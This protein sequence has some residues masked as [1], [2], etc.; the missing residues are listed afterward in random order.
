GGDGADRP[1]A[2]RS[3]ASLHPA[4]RV[5]GA[6]PVS[7]VQLDR[8]GRGQAVAV[9]IRELEKTFTLH[10]Q[11]GV[12]LPVLRRVSLVV[13]RGECVVLADPSGAGKSRRLGAVYG[14]SPPQGGHI[15]VRHGDRVVDMVGA[16]PRLVL[17]VRR[18]SVGYVSQFLRVIPR[19]P[20]VEVV[21]EPLRRI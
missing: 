12:T 17:D 15:L 20:A 3:P 14:T 10:V 11:G 8:D 7:L 13:R 9:E 21:A 1:G 18:R 19:V 6:P 4:P 5:L 16:E 2:G